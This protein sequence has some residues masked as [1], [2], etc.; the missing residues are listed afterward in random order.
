MSAPPSAILSDTEIEEI[1]GYKRA[2]AQVAELRRQ[3]FYRA[4][5]ARVT[6]YVILERQHYE[7]VC[8]G[9]RLTAANDPKVQ[10]RAAREPQ[11]KVTKVKESMFRAPQVRS[12][13]LHRVA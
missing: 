7:A 11:V 13:K 2:A 9:E 5:R 12:Q 8:G 3:G 10:F 1:T 4:R 6:G